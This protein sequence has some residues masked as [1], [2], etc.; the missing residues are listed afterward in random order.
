MNLKRNSLGIFLALISTVAFAA[1][2]DRYIEN[3]TSNKDIIFQVNKAGVKTE[4][5]RANGTTGAVSLKG[6]ANTNNYAK[7]YAVRV[8]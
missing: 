3:Q 7:F 6:V 5:M 1:P 8:R 2:G 4:V